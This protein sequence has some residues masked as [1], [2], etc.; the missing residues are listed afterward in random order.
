MI[1]QQINL[2]RTFLVVVVGCPI[3]GGHVLKGNVIKVILKV[4]V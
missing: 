2:Y 1:V 3:K 4:V